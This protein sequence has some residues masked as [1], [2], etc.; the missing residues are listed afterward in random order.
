[1]KLTAYDDVWFK[2]PVRTQN[3]NGST[4]MGG[5][6]RAEVILTW[7]NPTTPSRAGVLD[8]RQLQ[9]DYNGSVGSTCKGSWTMFELTPVK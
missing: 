1:M 3:W 5:K 9:R 8:D 2:F 6:W 7:Y 4:A